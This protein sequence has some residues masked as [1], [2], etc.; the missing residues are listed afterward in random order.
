LCGSHGTPCAQY[1]EKIHATYRLIC[2]TYIKNS[3]PAHVLLGQP[4]L[5]FIAWFL[6][7]TSLPNRQ[8]T[9]T[10]WGVSWADSTKDNGP[11][12]MSKTFTVVFKGALNIL[13]SYCFVK[14]ILAFRRLAQN[15][16]FVWRTEMSLNARLLFPAQHLTLEESDETPFHTARSDCI[17]YRCQCCNYQLQSYH[18]KQGGAFH[19]QLH[20]VSV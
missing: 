14:V 3:P 18:S 1:A 15:L 5:I 2:L 11:T 17:G 20:A 7:A 12:I 6:V 16:R 19:R 13:V 4:A 10:R 8:K 9:G